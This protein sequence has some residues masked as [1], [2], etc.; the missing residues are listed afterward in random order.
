M[1]SGKCISHAESGLLYVLPQTLR[2]LVRPRAGAALGMEGIDAFAAIPH[3][4][5]A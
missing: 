1:I 4:R 5:Q 2:S 3:L